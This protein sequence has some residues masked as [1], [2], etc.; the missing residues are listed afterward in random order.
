MTPAHQRSF[1]P[2][3]EASI[4]YQ[5]RGPFAIGVALSRSSHDMDI[6]VAAELPHPFFF[7]RPRFVEGTVTAAREQLSLHV[8]A[9]WRVRQRGKIELALLGGPSW[10]E[11]E[12]EVLAGLQFESEYPYDE[13][14]L[15]GPEV[16][17]HSSGTAGWHAG[18]EIA[19]W[20]R[21]RAGLLG[22]VRHVE[23]PDEFGLP[24]GTRVDLDAGGL[25]VLIGIRF[26]F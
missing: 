12:Q 16:R 1:A 22:T 25:Q 9:M 5:V 26:Q 4:G 7:S 10:F 17:L 20:L 13:A 24:D 15:T 21:P 2:S 11:F 14:T 19:W 3:L 23:G 8:S 18:A 6:D